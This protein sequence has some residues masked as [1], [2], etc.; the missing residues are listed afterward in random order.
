M[1]A[2][3]IMK[4]NSRLIYIYIYKSFGRNFAWVS[5]WTLHSGEVSAEVW[6]CKLLR[7]G[8]RG[9]LEAAGIWLRGEEFLSRDF[10]QK[11]AGS[12]GLPRRVSQWGGCW[13]RAGD[14]V[15]CHRGHSQVTHHPDRVVL[16]PL[17]NKWFY[18]Y[19][20]HACK[21]KHGNRPYCEAQARVRQG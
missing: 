9:F 16:K 7:C 21:N 3:L 10:S 13:H 17:K 15:R 14:N 8:V 19:C 2:W 4:E 18:R 20:N 12:L 11:G 5:R 1:V 6:G